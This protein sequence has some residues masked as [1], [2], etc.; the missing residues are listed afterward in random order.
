M[1]SGRESD[2]ISETDPLGVGDEVDKEENVGRIGS[3]A[4]RR[5]MREELRWLDTIP[6]DAVRQLLNQMGASVEGDAS[7]IRD[8]CV[9]CKLRE[10]GDVA[11][12]WKE[13]DE[14]LMNE[15]PLTPTIAMVDAMSQDRVRQSLQALLLNPE[16]V[17][18]VARNR[19][20]RFLSQAT[21]VDSQPTAP[22]TSKDDEPPRRFET[23]ADGAY[24]LRRT[25]MRE[26]RKRVVPREK[27]FAIDG[28]DEFVKR[29]AHVTQRRGKAPRK[30]Q[31]DGPGGMH[32]LAADRTAPTNHTKPKSREIGT[33]TD[34]DASTDA[35]VNRRTSEIAQRLSSKKNGEK[36]VPI[37]VTSETDASCRRS[38]Q[39]RVRQRQRSDRRHRDDSPSVTEYSDESDSEYSTTSDTEDDRRGAERRRNA[40]GAPHPRAHERPHERRRCVD[41][42]REPLRRTDNRRG[43]DVSDI[44]RKWKL[45]FTGE[46]DLGCEEFIEQLDEKIS[47]AGIH[48]DERLTVLPEVLKGRAI[49]W[50]RANRR[51]FETWREFLREFREWFCADSDQEGLKDD[52]RRRTQGMGESAKDYLICVQGLYTRLKKRRS[53]RSQLDQ[54]YAGL[55]PEYWDLLDRRDF[56]TYGE[57]AKEATRIERRWARADAHRPPPS[58][59]ESHAKEFAWNGPTAKNTKA[60]ETEKKNSRRPT[61]R[62]YRVAEIGP[63]ARESED[64]EPPT[65]VAGEKKKRKRRRTKKEGKGEIAGVEAAQAA[66][67]TRAAP[68]PPA[69]TPTA[70]PKEQRETNSGGNS[71]IN[72]QASS[73]ETTSVYRRPPLFCFNCG[74]AGH[75]GRDCQ[76]SRAILCTACGRKDVTRNDCGCALSKNARADW[77]QRGGQNPA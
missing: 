65:N 50:Y 11:V 53:V 56:R 29:S 20:K 40:R 43:R 46:D 8:R 1:A 77:S 14:P 17:P 30:V 54:A 6:D 66:S 48:R 58:R 70:V 18:A 24:N 23:K 62:A 75:F 35:E 22:P 32:E 5:K 13:E 36:K 19:L 38:D 7:E 41:E 9:R 69:P 3:H 59:A 67:N 57:L 10:N 47:A 25:K 73:K 64:S 28:Y 34:S 12:Q 45:H 71:R 37:R 74:E 61:T 72:Q 49:Q 15:G 52:I 42:R 51:Q 2:R 44:A 31:E 33:Q 16:G 21:R 68:S 39:D 60:S 27:D 55:R 63:E 26:Q 4:W 76:N